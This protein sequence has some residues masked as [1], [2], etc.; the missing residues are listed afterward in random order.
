MDRKALKEELKQFYR[1]YGIT[2]KELGKRMN[3][4]PQNLSAIINGARPGLDE[5]IAYIYEHWGV[6]FESYDK[7]FES[8]SV[9]KNEVQ[10][11]KIPGMLPEV[12][13]AFAAG[14]TNLINWN[15][16]T[17]RYWYLPDCTDC[18][19]VV[20]IEGN[21]MSP[22][23]PPGSFAVLKRFNVTA[24]NPNSIPFG[25]VFGVVVE[26]ESTGEYH[27]YI[28]VL[29]RY[30]DPEKASRYWIAHSFNPDYDDFDIHLSQVRSL[31]IVKQ[32]IVSN[33]AY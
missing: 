17:N 30:S 24:N 6:R 21:S 28:K 12:S 16:S 29:R 20:P 11:N 4:N 10:M 23:I 19:A 3:I 31:W 1:K 27:G 8:E 25:Q 15:E 26:D 9:S 33:M 7:E 2:Q 18:D 5:V 14:Q 22:N 13:F 32:H